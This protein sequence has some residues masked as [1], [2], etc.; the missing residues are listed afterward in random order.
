MSFCRNWFIAWLVVGLAFSALAQQPAPTPARARK[1]TA[2]PR[3]GYK[4]RVFN[5]RAP[6]Y[7]KKGQLRRLSPDQLWDAQPDSTRPN[8]GPFRL[9]VY[10]G[11]GASYYA[12]PLNSPVALVDKQQLRW[13]IPLSLRVMWQTDHRMRLG[14]ETG[15]V[16]MYS[17]KGT[18]NGELANVRVSATPILAVF[19][20]SV[21]KRFALYA[22]TGPY[23]I[24]SNLQ[25][26]GDTQGTTYSLGWMA[27]GTYTQPLGKNIGIAAELK[28]Y[29][30]TQTKDACFI[31][32]AT[33]V[34]RA[35]TW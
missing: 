15:Y 6:G 14:I 33:L 16:S 3:S 7:T 20:M 24:N 22:G 21:V 13:S 28:W 9:L 23:R 29:D 25:Y 35:L 12:T 11:L 4:Q 30:A 18:R 10:A 17:Y 31:A 2:K 34:W 26:D 8:R 5:A 32:Q 1:A 27:A 19:S